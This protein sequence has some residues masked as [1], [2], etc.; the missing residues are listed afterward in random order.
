MVL[1]IHGFGS[2]GC[3]KKASLLRS[4]FK[5]TLLAPSLSSIPNLAIQTLTELIT[6]LQSVHIQPRLMG[7]S[8][9]GYYALWLASQFD[10]KAVLINPS[11][12]PYRTLSDYIGMNQNY[13]DH[14]HYEWSEAHVRSLK[15]YE[16]N[17]ID[18]K[19]LLFLLQKGDTLLDYRQALHRFPN[20][21]FDI[22]NAGTHEYEGLERKLDLIHHFYTS[23]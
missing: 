17:T 22:E 14:T 5:N 16:V 4:R 9:G 18:E 19:N 2:S 13:Y 15:Q 10:L 1:Y 7:S 8:L 6:T 20:G 3:S 23:K 12:Y 11:I 21:A